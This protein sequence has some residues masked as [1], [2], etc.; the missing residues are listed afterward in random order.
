M[1]VKTKR[2]TTKIEAYGI[3]DEDGLIQ[4]SFDLAKNAIKSSYFNYMKNLLKNIFINNIKIKSY[5]KTNIFISYKIKS[6][7]YSQ[8]KS[9]EEIRNNFENEFLE[10]NNILIDEEIPENTINNKILIKEFFNCFPNLNDPKL[11]RLIDKLRKTEIDK[12]VSNY[13][14]MNLEGEK[15]GIKNKQGKEEIENMLEKDIIDP[16][17]DRIPYIS[18]S[19]IL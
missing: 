17:K 15:I 1:Y 11:I 7:I 9:L 12:L 19:F 18:L 8:N 14:N 3:F 10:I 5:L 13:M 16:I 4:K 6:V 2:K